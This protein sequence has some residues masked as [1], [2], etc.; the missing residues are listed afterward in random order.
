MDENQELQKIKGLVGIVQWTENVVV[1][2][3]G[4]CGESVNI[5]QRQTRNG[6]R[7]IGKLLGLEH[8]SL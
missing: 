4:R 3:K 8:F 6:G 7:R 1:V 2:K 5:L